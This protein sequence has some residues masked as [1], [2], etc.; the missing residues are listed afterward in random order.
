MAETSAVGGSRMNAAT[1]SERP[2][3]HHFI[4]RFLSRNFAVLKNPGQV[5]PKKSKK[6]N[7]RPPLPK[8]LN[9]LNLKQGTLEQ[10]D[11][12]RTFG[13][14]VKCLLRSFFPK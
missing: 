12:G 6:K 5:A 14:L 3:Y 11:V 10:G 7:N 2:Q 13:F 8:A 4:P 1:Q 9:Q